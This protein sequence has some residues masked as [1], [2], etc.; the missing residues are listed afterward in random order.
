LRRLAEATGGACDFVAPGE[1]VEPA[2]LRMFARLRSPRLN[3]VTVIW[4]DGFD[5]EWATSIP[6][7]VF[8]GDTVNLFAMANR[9]LKPGLE[10]LIEQFSK[11]IPTAGEDIPTPLPMAESNNDGNHSYAITE[12]FLGMPDTRA[13]QYPG[14]APPLVAYLVKGGAYGEIGGC[15][16][17]LTAHAV[18]PGA[19]HAGQ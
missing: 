15:D 10:R 17:G 4:P 9:V 3:D 6:K 12:E 19:S 11:K 1:A 16:A 2:I 5:T 8:D 7:S 14:T 13:P 18:A